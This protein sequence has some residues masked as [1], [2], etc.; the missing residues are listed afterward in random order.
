MNATI[1]RPWYVLGPG[2]RW[3]LLF[4]PFYALMRLFPQTRAQAIRLGLVSDEQMNAALVHAVEA[5]V[6]GICIVEVPQ[7]QQSAL[8]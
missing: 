7:I 8:R 6:E 4:E 1:L 2:R 3:P 5:P